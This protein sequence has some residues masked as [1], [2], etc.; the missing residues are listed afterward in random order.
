M[1]GA[2]FR[3]IGWT[4]LASTS[5]VVACGSDDD[6]DDDDGSNSTTATVGNTGIPT[7][8][9]QSQSATSGQTTT[10]TTGVTTS[11]TTT[12]TT[13]TTTTTGSTTGTSSTTGAGGGGGAGGEGGACTDDD[14]VEPPLVGAAGAA[15]GGGAAPVELTG[16]GWNFTSESEVADW[17]V[18]TC[19]AGT[20]CVEGPVAWACGVMQVT[21]NWP[22]AANAAAH[23]FRLQNLVP[24]EM[25]RDLAGRT[26]VVQARLTSE[27]V[28]SNGYDLNI[29]AQDYTNDNDDTNDWHWFATCWNGN[30]ACAETPSADLYAPGQGWQT[31]FLTM[32]AAPAEFV[33]SGVIK[34][35]IEIATK[36]YA[37]P[38]F[39]YDAG[40]TTFEINAFVW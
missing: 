20:T 2:N 16:E 18:E 6:G 13:T 40:P 7:T 34:L 25:L 19:A 37:G 33:T 15:G 9:T 35:G 24:P 29:F 21:I 28:G 31:A 12:G 8:T 36:Q 3:R 10:S 30:V 1:N 32:D 14:T 39:T 17:S 5:L 26:L 22:A 23:Q 38:T 27:Q 4:L 11:P